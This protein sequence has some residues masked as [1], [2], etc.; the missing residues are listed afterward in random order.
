MQTNDLSSF[1]YSPFGMCGLMFCIK[2][3]L[4]LYISILSGNGMAF[5]TH[6]HKMHILDNLFIVYKHTLYTFEFLLE[7]VSESK[8]VY[9]SFSILTIFIAPS[10]S[11]CAAQYWLKPTMP[12]NKSVT[13]SYLMNGKIAMAYK[14]KYEMFI[15]W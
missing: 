2:F 5:Y 1:R 13:Q 6:T 11:V 8:I 9:S 15:N 3:S 12:E 10:A 7:S 4:Y 14:A